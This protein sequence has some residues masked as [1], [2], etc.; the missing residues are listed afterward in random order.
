MNL[1]FSEG[2]L[3]DKFFNG[4]FS[5]I[6]HGC[7]CFNTMGSGIAKEIK[8]RIPEAYV[9]DQATIKGD[10]DKLGDY[11]LAE[12]KHGLVA[13]LYTQY[14]YWLEG[15]LVIWDKVEEA[16]TKL[17]NGR[18]GVVEKPLCIGIP[19]IGCGLAQGKEEDLLITLQ[20]VVD[21]FPTVEGCIELVRFKN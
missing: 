21:K 18:G 19:Y 14:T 2:N 11:T 16:L 7:N 15:E 1:T 8:D 3:I 9:V 20:K 13:N 6:A 10:E 12:T 4:E 17:I 5:V